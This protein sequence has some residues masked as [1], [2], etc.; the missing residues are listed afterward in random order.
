MGRPLGVGMSEKD[1]AG[2]TFWDHLTELFTRLRKSL[3]VF[4]ISTVAVMVVPISLDPTNVDLSNPFYQTIASFVIQSFQDRFL[5]PDITLIPVNFFAPLEV[6]FFVSIVLGSAI[7]LPVASYELY[8]FF[9]P[10]L[11]QNEKR[12][13]FQF[14]ASFVALFLFGLGLGY[15]YVVPLTFRTMILFSQL[16]NLTPVYDFSE[17]FSLVGTILLICGLIFTFPIFV[18]LLVKANI[19]KTEQ[20]TKN[21][22]YVYG[23][24]LILISV[25]DPDP[26]L[27]TEGVTF[28]P[29]VLLMELTI[30]LSKR[31]EKQ[32]EASN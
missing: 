2:M 11:R 28:I 1:T 25:L 6:Y 7:G 17:F 4:L 15:L 29:I 19:L 16:Q 14:I 30:L 27:V 23:F 32:R 21:R 10:A 22:K 18:Y 3:L 20:L 24:I 8:K 26:T 12:F 9:Q 31:V 13:A 5:P